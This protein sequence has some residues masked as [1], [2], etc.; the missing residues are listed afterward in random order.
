MGGA[1]SLVN[2]PYVSPIACRCCPISL[3]MSL[4]VRDI[5]F[6]A[7]HGSDATGCSLPFKCISDPFICTLSS[8]VNSCSD[9]LRLPELRSD[10]SNGGG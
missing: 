6:T 5:S 8:A 4:S 7:G 10:D 9:A 1:Y 2:K 3:M